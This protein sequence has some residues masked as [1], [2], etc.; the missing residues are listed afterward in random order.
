MG[1]AA[2]VLGAVAESDTAPVYVQLGAALF[3][4]GLAAR[5]AGRAGLSPIPLYLLAGLVLG[6]FDIPALDGEF[7]RFAAGLG[8]IL[9]LFVI[10]L[11][12]T[13]E[14][15]TGHLRRFHRAGAVD[16]A[17]NFPPGFLFGLLLG[18]DPVAAILLGGITWV[19]SSGIVAKALS[20]LGWLVNRET[21]AILS[22]LVIEDLAMAGFL[23]LVASLLVGG[24]LL[25]SIG[26]LA[27]A[28]TAAMAALVG[29]IRFGEALGRIVAHRSEEVVLLSAMGLVLV[30]SGVAE[31]L[32]VSAA[33]GAFLVGI[34]LS[35]EV[36]HRTRGLL[37]PIRDVNAALFF[38][39][40]A[41]QIDTGELGGVALP[42]LALA[43][44]TAATKAL[45]GWR[46]AA[47]A[48]ADE[49][50]RARAATA[51]IARGEFSIVLAGLGAGARIEP[52]LAPLAA[53]YVLIL[54]I[55]GPLLMHFSDE[56]AGH[57]APRP[58]ARPA[59]DPKPDLTGRVSPTAR[60]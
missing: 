21:H 22:V 59:P 2:F 20:D 10:G 32:Q 42:A 26:S 9:L 41:L 23:P 33:V 3:V 4:L 39:F 16:A 51:L 5:V 43:T 49:V 1:G 47:M 36:A 11:E 24:T 52:E 56:I 27:I 17:L 48:G 12:Y 45:A 46:A 7:I 53:C 34:A 18:W 50:G 40:F 44:L 54:A 15:L 60:R 28:A 19:S 31:E 55:A 58:R 38:L 35:G 37:S 25:A 29:A 6:S 57:A 8:V 30:A 13:A 14:E